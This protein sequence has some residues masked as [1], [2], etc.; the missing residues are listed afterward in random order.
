M[1]KKFCILFC[2]RR[3]KKLLLTMKLTLLLS[4]ILILNVNASI[5][6]QNERVSLN[7]DE[8]LLENMLDEIKKQSEFTFLYRSDLLKDVIVKGVDFKK[9]KINNILERVL[10]DQGYDYEIID[11][12]IIIRKSLLNENINEQQIVVKGNVTDSEGNPLP[13]VNIVEVGTTN[14]AVTDLDGN[15]SISVGSPGAT[16]SFS[17]V[18]FLTEEIEINNQ[19][20]IDIVLIEDIQ[21]LDEVVVIGYG[22]IKK[23]DL[24]GSVASVEAEDLKR[25]P[26]GSV[27]QALQGRASGVSVVQRNGEPGNG[28]V[29]RIRGT[30]S[31]QGGND[32]LVILDGFPITGSIGTINLNEIENIEILKDASATSIYGARATNGVVIITTKRGKAGQS[33]IDFSM[34]YGWQQ[35]TKKIDMMNASQFME[36]A[37][38]LAANDGNEPYFPNPE[39]I[40]YDTDW[41]DE[42]YRIAP[43]QNYNL[44]FSGGTEI[45]RYNISGDYFN[46][47]GIMY[48]SDYE[49]GT[50][51]AN[52]E[53]DI[54]K[55]LSIS[56]SLL[57]AR[58]GKNNQSD[59]GAASVPS[60]GALMAPPTLPVKNEEGDWQD[61]NIYGFSPGALTN[62]VAPTKDPNNLDQQLATRIFDNFYGIITFTDWLSFKSS[63]GIDYATGKSD[64]YIPRTLQ[65]GLPSGKASKS[66]YENYSLL[67]ENTLRFSYD[68]NEH[69][70]DAVAGYTWQRYET[71]SFS[72]SSYSFVTDDLLNNVLDSGSDPQIPSSSMS[73]WGIASWLGRVNYTLKNKYL[74]TVSGRADGSSRFSDSN[75]WAFFPSAAI[76]WRISEESFMKNQKLI[77]NLKFRASYGKTGNQAVSPYQTWTKMTA[78]DLALGDELHIGYVPGNIANKELKWETTSQYNIGFDIGV[79]DGRIQLIA[80]YFSKNTSDLLALVD[81]PSSSGYTSS[82]QNI[83]EMKNVGF[84]IE[85]D[86]AV[87]TGE[88]KWDSKVSFWKTENEIVKLAKGADVFA[89]KVDNLIPSI[90]ILREGYPISMFY[91]YIKDGYDENGI[92]KYKDLNGDE[93]VDDT[94]RDFIG[95]PHPDF[96]FGWNNQFSWKGFDLS[97]FIEG[98]QGFDIFNAANE[99]V[100]SSFYKGGNQIVEVY[101]DHWTPDNTD[102][103]YPKIT[104]NQSFNQSDAWIEDGSY[105]KIRN[106]TLGYNIPS[107]LIKWGRNARIYMSMQN[108][109]TFTNYSWYDPEVSSFDS[110]DLRLSVDKATYP[111]VKTIS[112]GISLGL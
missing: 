112:F 28:S 63:F 104:A 103:K 52:L 41:Q 109:F 34:Y 18:G 13:G 100:A 45:F 106:I 94:D 72:A 7:H 39:E 98:S 25:I 9:E 64:R 16:L 99:W 19:T 66:T 101:E 1:K 48:G 92:T 15:Y 102:A 21:S 88:F 37:N 78:T 81:L 51:R 111:K 60:M 76:A 70:V 12:T 6:S 54:N 65:G 26:V 79:L 46:Q 27:D 23:S 93:V 90:H 80:D 110:G 107:K 2:N 11:K 87:L 56:N 73:D 32:P 97:V 10:L 42:I 95:N 74:F 85:I 108:W 53:G 5:Y 71:T 14:G 55:W 96:Q 22:T 50:L 33:N 57:L 47:E 4:V 38:E 35:S 40:E 89:S 105:V 84:E 58:S 59:Y 77:S 62:P 61:V 3:F 43:I 8:I 36:I 82:T 31:I 68:F 69:S 20:K 24:T 44:A 91:G 29:I 49:R 86:A 17:F 67:N 83:G 30:N 75:K